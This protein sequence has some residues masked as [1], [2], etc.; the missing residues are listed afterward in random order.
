MP[1]ID[2]PHGNLAVWQAAFNLNQRF[3]FDKFCMSKKHYVGVNAFRGL[4][5][6]P[7]HFCHAELLYA[8]G[9]F[10]ARDITI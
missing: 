9:G 8:Q 1:P 5:Q 7:V 4:N 3:G 2:P 6:T 10:V